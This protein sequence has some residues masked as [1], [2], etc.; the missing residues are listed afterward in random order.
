MV[1]AE[2]KLSSWN[3]E[4]SLSFL[5]FGESILFVCFLLFEDFPYLDFGETSEEKSV[6]K[7]DSVLWGDWVSSGIGVSSTGTNYKNK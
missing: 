6:S 5:I 2:N 3:I 4:L 7:I 1:I